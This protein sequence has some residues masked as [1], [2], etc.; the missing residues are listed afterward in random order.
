M[1]SRR[2]AGLRFFA[3]SSSLCFAC[4][5]RSCWI[6]LGTRLRFGLR[7]AGLLLRVGANAALLALLGDEVADLLALLGDQ[8]AAFGRF[9]IF[10][11]QFVALLDLQVADLIARLIG[12]ERRLRRLTA[13]VTVCCCGAG[14]VFGADGVV[15]CCGGAE[16]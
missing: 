8:L 6:V 10:R 12:G 1:R 5:S 11:A 4:N 2:S 9:Q 3:R 16:R 13:G 7:A 14:P 15:A